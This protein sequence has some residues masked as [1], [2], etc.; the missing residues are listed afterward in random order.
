M[1]TWSRQHRS[2]WRCNHD[3]YNVARVTH[4]QGRKMAMAI[5]LGLLAAREEERQQL[6]LG[7]RAM[8]VESRE[9]GFDGV[10]RKR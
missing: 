8:T 2:R 1:E 10:W 9:M 6:A 3:D 4:S 7:K 5:L